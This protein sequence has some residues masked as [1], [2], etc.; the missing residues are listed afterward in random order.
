[1]FKNGP[2]SLYAYL[3]F[4]SVA[5]VLFFVMLIKRSDKPAIFFFILYL[6]AA[7][8]FYNSFYMPLIDKS[9][10]SLRLITDQLEPYK[11]TKEFYT[12][13]FDSAGIIFYV[14]KP[15]QENC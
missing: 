8:V 3:G 13:G 14:G 15:V 7:G 9:S 12:F 5:A 6:V 2:S 10:K 1:M 11:K 4:L